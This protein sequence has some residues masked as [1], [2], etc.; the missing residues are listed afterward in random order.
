MYGVWDD[1][2]F[3]AND[4]WGGLDGVDDFVQPWKKDVLKV[5]KQNWSNP[6]YGGGDETPG[7][8]FSFTCGDVEVFMLDCRYYRQ[9]PK[10]PGP[11][12]MLGPVQKKWL[13]DSVKASTATF[14]VLCSSVPWATGTKGNA[15]PDKWDGFLEER[16]EIFSTLE[17]AKV[18]GIVLISADR[19][20]AD[21]RRIKR[22]NGY[23]L[24]DFMTSRLSNGLNH[25]LV[26]GYIFAYH[27]K[28]MFGH[29]AFDTTL[30]DPEVTLSVITIDDELA[31]DEVSGKPC[32]ITFKLS[33]LSHP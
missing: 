29:L 28:P 20:R 30:A 5:F 26:K 18:D 12:T 3:G 19:H 24:Y 15:H 22:P 2:D 21:L 10:L 17:A 27:E 13:I 25:T 11:R 23:D 8:W 14:K 9:S 7:C 31:A 33:D 1:H 4:S 32:Q 6:W 16:E